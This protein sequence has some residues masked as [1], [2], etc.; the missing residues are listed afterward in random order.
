MA[1]TACG[2]PNLQIHG[3]VSYDIYNELKNARRKTFVSGGAHG[4]FFVSIAG[5]SE[6]DIEQDTD[7]FGDSEDED[8]EEGVIW[9]KEL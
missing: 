3:F 9:I 4:S 2:A 5:V 8:D 1:S 6:S 7:E